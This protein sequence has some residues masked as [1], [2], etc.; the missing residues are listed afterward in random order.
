MEIAREE[1]R[2]IAALEID[3]I[4]RLSD[5]ELLEHIARNM[6]TVEKIV[7]ELA[8]KLPAVLDGMEA[9]PMIKTLLKLIS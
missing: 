9:N 4:S 8:A 6:L 7:D 5:R 1:T 2:E 3:P